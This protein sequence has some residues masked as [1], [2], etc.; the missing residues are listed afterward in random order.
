MLAPMSQS[1]HN[2]PRPWRDIARELAREPD[3]LK[4]LT[5]MDELNESF[6]P[7]FATC[8]ICG[9]F[10][11]LTSCNTDEQGRPVHE[12]CYMMKVQNRA[13]DPLPT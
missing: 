11:E 4:R 10:C 9:K 5:L 1:A 7:R 2:T 13:N 6:D 8:A 3:R 12:H